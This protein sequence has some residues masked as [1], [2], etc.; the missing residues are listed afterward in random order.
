[1]NTK[2]LRRPAQACFAALRIRYTGVYALPLY[3]GKKYRQ[4]FFTKIILTYRKNTTT[5]SCR[6]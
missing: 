5:D 3:I 2:G 4:S 1:M 6:D